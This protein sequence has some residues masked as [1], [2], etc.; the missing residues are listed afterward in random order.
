MVNH[1]KAVL[2]ILVA[3]SLLF[4]ACARDNDEPVVTIDGSSTVFPITKAVSDSFEKREPVKVDVKEATKV[5]VG[6]SGTGGGF[7]RL[8][9]KQIDIANAS[10][11]ITLTERAHC[12]RN[13]VEFV[14]LPVAYDGLA[15]VVNPQNTWA[16]DITTEE[17][18]R[19][20]EP[21][22]KGKVTRWSQ[23][24]S[25]WPDEPIH[26]HGAGTDS[27]TYDYFREALVP[28]EAL[29]T[30]YSASEDDDVL[31]EAVAAD[32]N[33]LG[34]FGYA[35][36]YR[37]KDRLK[38][39]AVDDG[40]PEN[41][42]GPILPSPETVQAG[43]Y[44]PLSRP[45]FIYVSRA[46]LERREVQLFSSYYLMKG[47]KFAERVGY[48]GLPEKAYILAQRRLS[49]RQT[50]SIFSRTPAGIGMSIEALL[51]RERAAASK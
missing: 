4:A 43:T 24:R 3:G 22:A 17:L 37:N 10:R 50:G 25:G 39:L 9:N 1:S 19:L 28:D 45:L 34:F 15:V 16:S 26:L 27:G 31:V 20:W 38:R 36:V 18:R 33:A 21:Q 49:A 6:I 51:E 8:C 48:V 46:A 7:R 13:G 41:G 35:Y 11:P 30:D 44:Q 40:K 23:V 42:A 12:A 2:A 14:E 32:R 5:Q 29:R 47:A